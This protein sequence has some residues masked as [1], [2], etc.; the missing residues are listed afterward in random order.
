MKKQKPIHDLI[1]ASDS[2]HSK[3]KEAGK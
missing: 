2:L 3:E 1:L